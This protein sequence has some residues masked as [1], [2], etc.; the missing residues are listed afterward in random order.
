MDETVTV[1]RTWAL[2]HP[3]LVIENLNKSYF[4]IHSRLSQ[5]VWRYNLKEMH[6][7]SLRHASNKQ[8]EILSQR[9]R[10]REGGLIPLS[11]PEY[12]PQTQ[13]YF[14]RRVRL[15][16]ENRTS[17]LLFHWIGTVAGDCVVVIPWN[18]FCFVFCNEWFGQSIVF[19]QFFEATLW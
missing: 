6:W 3:R 18:W 8:R 4:A 5:S 15:R 9:K 2:L 14:L 11:L 19:W 17:S 12:E 10:Q 13:I 1:F 7:Y 16:K